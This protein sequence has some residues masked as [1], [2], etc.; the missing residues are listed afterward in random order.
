MS[1]KVFNIIKLQNKIV[2]WVENCS[3]FTSLWLCGGLFERAWKCAAMWDSQNGFA[4][5]CAVA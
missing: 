5:K 2:G 3:S 1:L 4:E